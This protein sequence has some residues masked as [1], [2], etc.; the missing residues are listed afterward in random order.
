MMKCT[1]FVELGNVGIY[2]YEIRCNWENKIRNLTRQLGD[3]DR[4]IVIMIEYVV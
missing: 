4:T 1:G 3:G 2:L